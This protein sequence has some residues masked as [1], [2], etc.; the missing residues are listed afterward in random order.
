MA[1]PSKMLLDLRAEVNTM[2]IVLTNMQKELHAM[3]QAM[4]DYAT[5]QAVE[6]AVTEL[7]AMRQTVA[8]LATN[9]PVETAITE[10][11][12]TYNANDS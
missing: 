6:V 7:R 8:D 12:G 2:R 10:T 4:A 3:R 11:L 9:Q 1:E 5:N